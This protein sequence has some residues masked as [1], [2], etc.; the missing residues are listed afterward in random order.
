MHLEI[1]LSFVFKI[2]LISLSEV[3]IGALTVT[4]KSLF[5]LI[6]IVFLFNFIT[7]I[8]FITLYSFLRHN[9]QFD[10]KVFSYNPIIIIR[11]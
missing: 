7:V 2:S 10:I 11:I 6:D 9:F 5:T 1:Q 3:K 8:L 4:V